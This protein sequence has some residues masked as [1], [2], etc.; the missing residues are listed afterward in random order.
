M[1]PKF[2]M[3]YLLQ[4]KKKTKTLRALNKPSIAANWVIYR[5]SPYRGQEIPARIFTAAEDR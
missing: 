3:Q 4:S 2:P 1:A 5:P